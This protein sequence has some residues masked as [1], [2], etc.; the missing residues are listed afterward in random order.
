MTRKKATIIYIAVL[1]LLIVTTLLALMDGGYHISGGPIAALAFASMVT[2]LLPFFMSL[3]LFKKVEKRPHA[4][5]LYKIWGVIV[6]L[7]CFPVKVLII[8]A[9]IDLLVNGGEG[10][11]FG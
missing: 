4:S 7:F 5:R 10:W 6:Y 1:L 2:S 3:L 9:N 11:A 8:Y